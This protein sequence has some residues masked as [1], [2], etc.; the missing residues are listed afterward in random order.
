MR[1]ESL[2]DQRYTMLVF[3]IC[4]KFISIFQPFY[5]EFRYPFSTAPI[6]SRYIPFRSVFMHAIQQ[7]HSEC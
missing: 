6:A 5:K 1:T 2:H 3:L 4:L 7:R